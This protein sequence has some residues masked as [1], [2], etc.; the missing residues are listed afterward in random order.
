MG[1]IVIHPACVV[2]VR[3]VY[4]SVQCRVAKL[5]K[6]QGGGGGRYRGNLDL[7]HDLGKVLKCPF[8]SISTQSEYNRGH[9]K[10]FLHSKGLHFRI[11]TLDD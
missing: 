1:G 11:F 4:N 2:I 6:I 10:E 3:C 8:F 5:G 9:F 7:S